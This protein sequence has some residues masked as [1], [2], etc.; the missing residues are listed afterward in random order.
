MSLQE[1]KLVK[2]LILVLGVKPKNISLYKSALR[3]K[4]VAKEIKKGFKD[5]NERLEF[6][7]DAV[8]DTA[9]AEYLFKKYPYKDEGFL[10]EM[11]AK[12]VN[13]DSINTLCRKIGL[14]DYIQ[15]SSTGASLYGDGLEA[16]IGAIYLDLGYESAKKF[17][18]DKLLNNHIDIHRLEKEGPNPKSVVIEWAQKQNKKLE[19]IYTMN[20]TYTTHLLTLKI[21]GEVISNSSG[22]S[23]K[24][25]AQ[26]ASKSA[27]K[28]LKINK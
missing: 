22:K 8:L 21:N 28:V 14:Y 2:G 9:V 20:D 19:F 23:K 26:E 11:R 17:V 16:I 6:L 4:S 3:H 27:I 12:I 18:I 10:T 15:H 1:K 7:G 5:S 25:A 24:T 13:G